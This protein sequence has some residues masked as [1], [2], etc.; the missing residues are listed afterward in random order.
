MLDHLQID[1]A[2][3]LGFSNGGT[4]AYQ[5]AIRH[6][7]RVRKIVA[8]SGF[9][10]HAGAFPAF[11]DSFAHVQLNDMPKSLRDAYLAVAPN[12]ANLQSFFEKCVERM[13]HFQDIPE[14]VMRKIGP[15]TLVICGDA[16]VMRP[17]HAVETYRLIPH[18]EVAVLPGTDHMAIMARTDLLMPIIVKFL[19]APAVK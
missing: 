17:E 5:I 3:L 13:R 2:D 7:E 6:P 16:D 19:D 12:P 4:I 15:P 11:W 10:S 9:F 14:D 18:S 8:V 1:R